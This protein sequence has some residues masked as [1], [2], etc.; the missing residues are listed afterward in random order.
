MPNYI[1]PE[2]IE[3]YAASKF[4]KLPADYRDLIVS[5]TVKYAKANDSFAIQSQISKDHLPDWANSLLSKGEEVHRFKPNEQLEKD[6]HKITKFINELVEISKKKTKGD[7][8]AKALKNMRSIEHSHFKG[9]LNLAEDWFRNIDRKVFLENTNEAK[10]DLD[11]GDYFWSPA[12]QTSEIERWGQRLGGNCLADGHYHDE[13]ENG[14]V[15]IWG[16]FS[17][18]ENLLAVAAFMD[19]QLADFE[20][21][22]KDGDERLENAAQYREQLLELIKFNNYSAT[23]EDA[24][25]V[26]EIHGQTDIKIY[27]DDSPAYAM[28]DEK[29][30]TLLIYSKLLKCIIPFQLGSICEQTSPS[31]QFD[32]EYELN[33]DVSPEVI[34]EICVALIQAY[35]NKI[36]PEWFDLSQLQEFSSSGLYWKDPTANKFSTDCNFVFSE[37][38]GELWY[39]YSKWGVKKLTSHDLDG[40]HVVDNRNRFAQRFASKEQRNRELKFICKHIDAFPDLMHSQTGNVHLT[41]T[42][43]N[44]KVLKPKQGWKLIDE[45]EDQRIK[46][47]ERVVD[48]YFETLQTKQVIC[49]YNSK[50]KAGCLVRQLSARKH[51]VKIQAPGNSPEAYE[52]MMQNIPWNSYSDEY[53][54]HSVRHKDNHVNDSFLNKNGNG[55]IPDENVLGTPYKYKAYKNKALIFDENNLLQLV[56]LLKGDVITHVYELRKSKKLAKD[57]FK[58]IEVLHYQLA[59][60]IKELRV[61]GIKNN[62]DELIQTIRY[63]S[64]TIEIVRFD[65]TLEINYQSEDDDVCQVV[66][67]T[68]EISVFGSIASK[69]QYDDMRQALLFTLN[70]KPLTFSHCSLS[71]YEILVFFGIMLCSITNEFF[72]EDLNEDDTPPEGWIINQNGISNRLFDEEQS[73]FYKDGQFNVNYHNIDLFTKNQQAIKELLSWFESRIEPLEEHFD[74]VFNE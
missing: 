69:E 16:L 4:K 6:L 67:D 7:L 71:T 22:G 27:N 49:S 10:K 26:L 60:S 8:H 15:E 30:Q 14:E 23:S 73:L 38:D 20:S 50:L 25:E 33:R 24:T 59:D 28:F 21:R 74:L 40:S 39:Q 41:P 9:L 2:A 29:E 66:I 1:Y 47:Y 46:V 58:I 65:D 45:S 57:F 63:E 18:S 5:K 32:I 64:N 61:L 54:E 34:D 19:N 13:L 48:D 56:F 17:R 31:L 70:L 43:S 11:L 37:L 3:A 55:I 72:L 12:S 36:T 35:D 42:I 44:G 51:D 62:V 68:D 52:F 53:S